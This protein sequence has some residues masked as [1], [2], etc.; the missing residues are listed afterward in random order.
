MNYVT[1]QPV[2]DHNDSAPV[3]KSRCVSSQR[4]R[5]PRSAA[6]SLKD[7]GFGRARAAGIAI[8]TPPCPTP[9][10]GYFNAHFL[11]LFQLRRQTVRLEIVRQQYLDELNVVVILLQCDIIEQLFKPGSGSHG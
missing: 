9:L 4:D 10:F 3:R 5:D 8:A 11:E 1:A 2:S 6:G 7:Q